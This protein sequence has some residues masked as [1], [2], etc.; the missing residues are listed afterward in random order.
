MRESII[1]G[2]TLEIVYEGRTHNA[3][4][5]VGIIIVNNMLLV[6]FD[7][8]IEQ[9]L[10]LDRVISNH[11]LLQAIAPNSNLKYHNI[12][13]SNDFLCLDR[14]TIIYARRVPTISV[15]L[16]TKSTIFACLISKENGQP[17]RSYRFGITSGFTGRARSIP[18]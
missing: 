13:R 14:L 6:G 17:Q 8:P 4:I 5:K 18:D 1:D 16:S 10:Y 12:V 7:A 15:D 9:V 3:E 2:T 11:N